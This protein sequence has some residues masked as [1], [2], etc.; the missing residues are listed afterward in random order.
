MYA[1]TSSG[2]DVEHACGLDLPIAGEAG[3]Q[4]NRT[5]PNLSPSAPK[6]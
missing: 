1:L 6:V 3:N 5:K 2:W 4:K